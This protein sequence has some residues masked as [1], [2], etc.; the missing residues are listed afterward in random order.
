MFATQGTALVIEI[1]IGVFTILSGIA[2]SIKWL[3]KHYFA[4]IKAEF[5]PN[6]G[7]SLKDQVNRLE[8]EINHIKEHMIK[9]EK[10]QE[11][12]NK[13]IDRMYSTIIDFISNNKN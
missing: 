7:S 10:E 8:T 12:I 11:S 13:K 3:V 6:G 4:E 5:K 1:I 2:F 9:E